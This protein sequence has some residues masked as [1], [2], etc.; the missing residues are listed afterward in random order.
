MSDST[1]DEKTP[2]FSG[3]PTED[4]LRWRARIEIH[5]LSK[6]LW[7]YAIT[8]AQE[9][10]TAEQQTARYKAASTLVNALGPNAFDVVRAYF[11]DPYDVLKALDHRYS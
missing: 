3:L 8:P 2:K 6:D 10:T 7:V 5:M 9:A 4:Y 1:K 11:K